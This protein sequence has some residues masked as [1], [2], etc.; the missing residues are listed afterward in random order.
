MKLA[1]K[2]FITQNELEADRIAVLKAKTD[3]KLAELERTVLEEYD[4]DAE[5]KRLQGD[6][7]SAKRNLEKVK[8][9]A[10]AETAEK[11]QQVLNAE[12]TLLIEEETLEEY[13][14]MQNRAEVRAPTS[15]VVIFG[16]L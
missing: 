14:A 13:I 8:L 15:G 16:F 4:L 7:D 10:D 2:K 5:Q 9:T 6:V 12:E 11:R 3:V 1:D